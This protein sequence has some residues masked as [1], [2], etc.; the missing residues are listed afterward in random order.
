M[1]STTLAPRPARYGQVPD[2][3]DHRDHLYK[4][5]Y[6][7]QK[8]TPPS[9]DLTTVA[10]YF[11]AYDQLQLGACTGNGIAAAL[12]YDGLIEAKSDN[13]TPSRL[14]IY[15]NERVLEG[16]V[17]SDS[18]AQ[19]R[20]GLH[21]V[22]HVGAP[23]ET[24]WPYDITQF[25]KKPPAT[26]YKAAPLDSALSYRRLL[27]DAKLSQFRA[28]LGVDGR[29]FVLGFSVYE[30]FESAAVAKNGIVPMP[31]KGEQLLGGH[32]VLAV[33]YDDSKQMVYCRNSWG[34]SWGVKGHFWMPYA[35][36][37]TASLSSD[38]WEIRTTGARAAA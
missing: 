32:C 7:A 11:P 25:K 30:S 17:A 15:Y 27:R 6:G 24:D 26:A 33:G 19:I 36:F 2:L 20:D 34:P 37:T 3:P 12:Q 5:A 23:P 1:P 16:T 38:F 28:C 21:T 4:M 10:G 14:F 18:G 9:S 13:F 8:A 29:P 31:E 22:A 35:Y